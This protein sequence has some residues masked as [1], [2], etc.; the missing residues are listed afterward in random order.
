[1]N[2]RKCG[3]IIKKDLLLGPRGA[4]YIWIIFMPFIMTLL[5]RLVFGGLIDSSPRLGIF[6]PGSS[7]ITREAFNTPGIDTRIISSEAEL[8]SLVEGNNLDAGLVLWEGFD[9]ALRSGE[10]P[11]L[12]V[13]I[14]GESLASTRIVL[15]VTLVDLIR[16]VTGAP[17][18]VDVYMDTLG[19]QQDV[20]ISERLVPLMVLMAVALSGIFFPAAS[21]VQERQSR[22]LDAVLVTP[23][24]VMEVMTAKGIVGFFLAFFVGGLTLLLNGGFSVYILGN[25][26]VLAVASLMCV[27]F[28]LILGCSVKDMTT[29]FTVFKSGGII[30]F[31]PAV[32]FLFP[33][34]PRWI[35]R[36]FPTYYFL[37][38]L[39]D[40]VLEGSGFREVVLDLGIGLV[41]S[42]ALIWVVGLL[43]RRMEYKLAAE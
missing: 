10:L 11:E 13:F 38:P 15:T 19:K 30:L 3:S 6:D 32:L 20:P 40:M 36:I 33:D 31:A 2:L 1:M 18:P 42:I 5:I 24:N 8:K 21:I 16:K 43:S 22:T 25:L 41:M 9:K 37:G 34:V 28:G 12:R 14:S 4:L 35:A 29:M 27:Q 26:A 39:Y 23:V 7:E 17:F